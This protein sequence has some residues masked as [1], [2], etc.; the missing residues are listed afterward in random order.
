MVFLSQPEHS[1]LDNIQGIFT[2]IGSD[3]CHAECP[4]FNR[5]QKLIHC[6]AIIPHGFHFK[7]TAV[8]FNPNVNGSNIAY[9]SVLWKLA[10]W[11]FVRRKYVHPL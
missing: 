3:L 4:P 9:F 10:S 1:V 5:G 8:Y 6:Q 11:G 7:A 2:A